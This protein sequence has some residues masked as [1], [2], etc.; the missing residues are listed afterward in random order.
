MVQDGRRR[1]EQCACRARWSCVQR[2]LSRA[3][4][5]ARHVDRRGLSQRRCDEGEP[6]QKGCPRAVVVQQAQPKRATRAR[7]RGH[8]TSISSLS[9]AIG[10]G[11]AWA[12]VRRLRRSEQA[13]RRRE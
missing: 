12:S 8:S 3:S 1:A 7:V 5:V 9:G 13:Q 10:D 11:M 2:E 4:W 6:R